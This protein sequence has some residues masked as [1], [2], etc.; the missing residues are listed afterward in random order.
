MSHKKNINDNWIKLMVSKYIALIQILNLMS[1]KTT[2]AL[3]SNMVLADQLIEEG[4]KLISNPDG[5]TMD[6]NQLNEIAK[7]FQ[8]ISNIYTQISNS[9]LARRELSTKFSLEVAHDGICFIVNDSD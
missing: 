2:A 5:Q 7:K 3:R 1:I 9:I 6:K 8:S 4:K